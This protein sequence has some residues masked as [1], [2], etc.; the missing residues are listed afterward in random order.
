MVPTPALR[1]LITLMQFYIY[2][3]ICMHMVIAK[4]CIGIDSP[5]FNGHTPLRYKL[6]GLLAF[7]VFNQ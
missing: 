1:P 2:T 4:L 3:H 5:S 6:D 7:S